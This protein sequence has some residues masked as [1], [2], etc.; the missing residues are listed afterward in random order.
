[1]NSAVIEFALKNKLKA[2]K[3]QDETNVIP[4]R[5]GH[6]YEHSADRLGVLYSSPKDKDATRWLRH[7]RACVAA[8]M[9][10]EQQGDF[11]GALTFNPSNATESAKAIQAAGCKAKTKRI[12]SESAKLAGA[13]RLA[14]WRTAQGSQLS[15]VR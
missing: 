7:M 9:T 14:S 4:G 3:D 15:K 11:E 12:M 8:G 1:M 2:Q 5:T 6:I 13:A 10:L